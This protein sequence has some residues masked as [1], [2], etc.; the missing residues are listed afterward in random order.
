MIN[1]N[2]ESKLDPTVKH[3]DY[4]TLDAKYDLALDAFNGDVTQYIEKL[5]GQT[6]LEYT[7]YQNRAA[8]LNVVEKSTTTIV[9][10]MTRKPYKLTGID[11]FPVNDYGSGDVFI[12]A[13]QRDLLLGARCCILVDAETE[14]SS[15]TTSSKLISYDA[16]AVINWYGDGTKP[17][18]FRMI[19]Q[20]N[21]VRDKDN[22]YQLVPVVT[23]REVY[24]DNSDVTVDGETITFGPRYGTY[25]VRIWSTDGTTK[26]FVA[27]QLPPLLAKGKLLTM[28]PLFVTTPFD[29]S[30]DIFNP[31]LYT[32]AS[33]NIKHFQQSADIAHYAHFMALPT[34]TIAGD[35]ASYTDDAGVTTT[36]KIAIGSTTQ[37]LH[38][39]SGSLASYTEINGQSGSFLHAEL[40]GI[41]ERMY[42]VGAN[43]L[44][45]KNGVESAAAL[46]L[47]AGSEGGM[48]ETITNALQSAINSALVVC[49]LID[50][51]PLGTIELNS[52]FTAAIVDPQTIQQLLAGVVNGV[53]TP[54]QFLQ[55]MYEGD[56]I[57]PPGADALKGE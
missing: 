24:L 40:D 9:G 46:A 38:L 53:I 28:I 52:D 26:K 34:F 14:E 33:L 20:T 36:A 47:R 15:G 11:T 3:P 57:R 32:Q 10:A 21:L 35:L 51:G 12:Q 50:G 45:T 4:P 39:T 55:Q 17:G 13:N 29:N 54:E 27:T 23:Y 8:Y 42:I 22:P 5:Q 16:C 6:A 18:D 2:E 1:I 44:T 30:W 49:Q 19:K 37:A 31:P 48:L 7:A 43:I 56:V 41:E 25:Q